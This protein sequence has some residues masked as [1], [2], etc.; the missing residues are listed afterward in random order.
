MEFSGRYRIDAP[1]GTVWDGL[2][3]PALLQKCIPGCERMEK[4]GPADFAA[5]VTLRIGPMKAT[6]QGKVRLAEQEPP[7]RCILTGEGQGGVAGFAKGSAQ[8]TLT[9]LE[10]GTELAYT[11]RAQVGGKLAQIGQRLIDGTARQLADQF[12]AG[13]SAA[14]ASPPGGEAPGAATKLPQRANPERVSP[15][16]W[17]TGLVAVSL[18]LILMFSVVMQ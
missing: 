17:M 9:P 1:L 3:D 16:I 10:G 7:L 15:V 8:V 2:N 5:V 13:F 14:L 12:F 6:F 11:A 4:S 18:I